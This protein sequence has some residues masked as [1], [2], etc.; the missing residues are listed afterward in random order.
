MGF[1]QAVSYAQTVLISQK[2]GRAVETDKLSDQVKAQDMWKDDVRKRFRSHQRTMK[3]HSN[4][5]G[6]TGPRSLSHHQ[7]CSAEQRETNRSK[8]L[9]PSLLF[10]YRSSPPYSLIF[11]FSF[12]FCFIFVLCLSLCF[13]SLGGVS[14]VFF[15]QCRQRRLNSMG[16]SWIKLLMPWETLKQFRSYSQGPFINREISV[17]CWV[18][19]ILSQLGYGPEHLKLGLKW[20]WLRTTSLMRTLDSNISST[21]LAFHLPHHWNPREST[22]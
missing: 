7:R 9:I 14:S 19:Q 17:L 3:T 2:G 10:F 15:P 5:S 11:S 12:Y 4:T 1:W 6:E 16:R 22:I 20:F 8:A 13:V 18:Y 21:L